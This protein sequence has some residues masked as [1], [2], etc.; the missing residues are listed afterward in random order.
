[1]TFLRTFFFCQKKKRER[2]NLYVKKK[3]PRNLFTFSPCACC[4]DFFRE[5]GFLNANTSRQ[6]SRNFGKLGDDDREKPARRIFDFQSPDSRHVKMIS[7]RRKSKRYWEAATTLARRSRRAW[8]LQVTKNF[9]TES[10]FKE[11]KK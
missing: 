2:E 5:R 4:R 7:D 11:A 1:M 6:G 9:S 3:I 8:S 10:E